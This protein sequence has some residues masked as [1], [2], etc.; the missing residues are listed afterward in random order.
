MIEEIL[1]YNDI[2][3]N[4]GFYKPFASN[5]YPR[6]RLA[7]LTC[8]DTRLVEL[9]P[10]ALGIHNGDVKLIKNAGGMISD[11]F[12]STIRSLLIAVLEFGVEEVMVIGHTDCGA[13]AISPETIITH[14][15]Q[16]GITRETILRLKEEGLDFESWFQGFENTKSSV[17][18]SVSLLKDHPLMP[19]NVVIR[20][21]VMDITCG[22]LDPVS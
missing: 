18:N 5:K 9:L 8:M 6:K 10:A 12:D 4:S 21:F 16:R 1:K 13:A 7:I 15:I 14:L 2:F 3:V 11:P 20:G 22:R 17:Q 19:A